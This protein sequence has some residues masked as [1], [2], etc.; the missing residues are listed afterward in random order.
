MQRKPPRTGIYTNGIFAAALVPVVYV[1]VTGRHLL[2]FLPE[3]IIWGCLV[4]ALVY[5][6]IRDAKYHSSAD[7]TP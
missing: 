2:G 3:M 1:I 7:R 6:Q 4:A 5:V